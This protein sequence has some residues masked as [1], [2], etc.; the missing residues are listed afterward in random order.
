MS[1]AYTHA[2]FVCAAIFDGAR[3]SCSVCKSRS[4]SKRSEQQLSLLMNTARATPSPV[5]PLIFASWA[6]E[7]TRR[8]DDE[9]PRCKKNSKHFAN[10]F[11]QQAPRNWRTWRLGEKSFKKFAISERQERVWYIKAHYTFER[12][13]ALALWRRRCESE[14]WLI[15]AR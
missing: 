15:I 4:P 1:G 2:Q 13:S 7:R 6:H 12:L 11:I 14:R 3:V 9:S 5:E 8:R 10:T